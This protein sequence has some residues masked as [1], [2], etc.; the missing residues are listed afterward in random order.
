MLTIFARH[1]DDFSSFQDDEDGGF[2]PLA[3]VASREDVPGVI[4]GRLKILSAVNNGH[5]P[6]FKEVHYLSESG[7]LDQLEPINI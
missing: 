6:N 2:F 7:T 1:L 5:G 4:S 3:Q